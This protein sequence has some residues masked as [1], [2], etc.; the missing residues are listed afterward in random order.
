VHVE[1][2]AAGAPP[3]P[4][5]RLARSIAG[6]LKP[7][8]RIPQRIFP[9]GP[10][11]L[12]APRLKIGLHSFLAARVAVAS[13]PHWRVRRGTPGLTVRAFA[14]D[15]GDGVLPIHTSPE[16]GPP[17]DQLSLRVSESNNREL[18]LGSFS[19]CWTRSPLPQNNRKT[20]HGLQRQPNQY[21]QDDILFDTDFLL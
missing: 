8:A 16:T 12:I 21:P 7:L 5:A 18:P 10:I 14:N 2:L 6:R 4:A 9:L 3:E 15:G 19:G 13:S 11:P 20:F 1:H 17:N